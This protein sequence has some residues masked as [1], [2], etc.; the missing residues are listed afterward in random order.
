MAQH[1]IPEHE[2]DLHQQ[3]QD[4]RCEPLLH[5]DDESG[6]MVWQHQI[7]DWEKLLEGFIKP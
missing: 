3:S 6:E 7:L 4:C 1:I 5:I 2:L